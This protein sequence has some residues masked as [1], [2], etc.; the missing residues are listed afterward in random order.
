MVSYVPDF[1]GVNMYCFVEHQSVTKLKID[2]PL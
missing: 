2:S 1:D